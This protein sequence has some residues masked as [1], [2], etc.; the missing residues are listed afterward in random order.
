M[1]QVTQEE[2]SKS[3]VATVQV[4]N[5]GTNTDP[6]NMTT[7]EGKSVEE[8]THA[9]VAVQTMDIPSKCS[10]NNSATSSPEE[11]LKTLYWHPNH[12]NR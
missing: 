10:I 11:N 4:E 6:M 1:E 5:K 9:D 8:T 12:E 7:Q 3:P 2:V